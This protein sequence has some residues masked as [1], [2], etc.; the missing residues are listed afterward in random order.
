M[1]CLI[2]FLLF[3]SCKAELLWKEQPSKW[4]F[5]MDSTN[6]CQVRLQNGQILANKTQI[7]NGTTSEIFAL[8]STPYYCAPQACFTWKQKSLFICLNY[9]TGQ[10]QLFDGGQ[11]TSLSLMG[12]MLRFDTQQQIYAL[13]LGRAICLFDIG[14]DGRPAQM[15]ECFRP[16]IPPTLLITDMHIHNAQIWLLGSGAVY[17]LDPETGYLQME[18]FTGLNFFPFQVFN[19]NL[20][21][22]SR[23]TSSKI[24]ANA[25]TDENLSQFCARMAFPMLSLVELILLIVMAYYCKVKLYRTRSGRFAVAALD[26]VSPS[27]SFAKSPV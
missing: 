14:A 20:V 23:G 26:E 17:R 4:L 10:F 16:L 1:I 6:V 12:R 7:Q 13:W 25:H 22:G 15:R 18:L 21:G 9:S 5:A 27:F 19:V 3:I 2:I 24:T 11:H 8:P